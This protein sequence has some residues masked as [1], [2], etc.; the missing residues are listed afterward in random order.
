MN[1]KN[2]LLNCHQFKYGGIA[3]N[4]LLYM[5]VHIFADN[6]LLI[7]KQLFEFILCGSPRLSKNISPLQEAGKL[8]YPVDNLV[9]DD[10]C[11]LV[12]CKWM[13]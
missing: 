4:F 9:V 1:K 10:L 5:R 3:I 6:Q 2:A 8:F 11:F 13:G 7:G 12:S